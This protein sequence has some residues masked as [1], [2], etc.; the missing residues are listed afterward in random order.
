MK[1][2]S[3]HLCLLV[4]CIWPFGLVA[5]ASEPVVTTLPANDPVRIEWELIAK[6]HQS[7]RG[8]DE[9]ATD[10]QIAATGADRTVAP[11]VL[12][13]RRTMAVC[14][15]L[16][17]DNEY[18]RAMKVA[19]RALKQLAT[20]KENNDTD[21]EERLYWEALLEGRILDHD[22]AH[23]TMSNVVFRPKQMTDLELRQGQRYVYNRFYSIPSIL[24]RCC[25]L[26]GR[27]LNRLLVNFSYRAIGQGK[28]IHDA[29]PA[30]ER[31]K[32]ARTSRA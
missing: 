30:Q 8:D 23:Y 20:M 18:G 10:A 9:A 7:A 32:S 17:N 24:K 15:W 4:G 5:N 11:S 21:R 6:A 25:T 26:R 1:L 14:G 13:A 16:Q 29:L 31:V 12:L 22:W 28:G 2:V 27:L 19:Q 3:L